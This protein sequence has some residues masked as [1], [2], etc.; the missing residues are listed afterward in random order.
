[1]DSSSLDSLFPSL[2]EL[3]ANR[4]ADE[5]QV[6]NQLLTSRENYIAEKTA[7]ISQTLQD[8]SKK[9]LDSMEMLHDL[10]LQEL[11]TLSNTEKEEIKKEFTTA[12]E[13]LSKIN[14]SPEGLIKDPKILS[15]D[16]WQGFLGLSSKTLLWLYQIGR[17][18][19]E[20]NRLEEALTFFQLLIMLNTLDCDH[21][22][23]LGFTQK[24]LSQLP[25]ALNSFAVALILNPKNPMPRYQSAK[26]YLQ[27]GQFE[28]AVIELDIL[29]EIIQEE[30]L[31]FL[32]SE[33][34]ILY[35]KAKIRQ[36]L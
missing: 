34:E 32:K 31:D 7:S 1:M 33:V 20:Q 6:K 29:S 2:A 18:H 9:M 27:L 30:S 10:L 19:Y 26:L 25:E 13:R 15:S 36:S 14:A 35:N 17:Q 21:W 23:G 3:L 16:T 11:A 24:S 22:I 12:L 5:L 8:Q 28:D 4:Q